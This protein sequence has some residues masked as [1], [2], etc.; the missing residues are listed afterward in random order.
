LVTYDGGGPASDVVDAATAD[1]PLFTATGP[2]GDEHRLWAVT[3]PDR[4]AAVAA[5]LA[6]RQALIAGGHHRY[7]TS[8]APRTGRPRAA[9]CRAGGGRGSAGPRDGRAAAPR[10]GGGGPAPGGGGRED[11]EEVDVVRPEAAQR[12]RAAYA[13]PGLI[14]P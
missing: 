8:L 12:A 9:R 5:A 4:L 2:G 3:A 11:A 13:R 7:A 6:P 14:R 10:G 1:A